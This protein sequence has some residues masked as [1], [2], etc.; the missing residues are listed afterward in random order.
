MKYLHIDTFV[1]EEAA[2]RRLYVLRATGDTPQQWPIEYPA[3]WVVLRF[4]V[5]RSVARR[6]TARLLAQWTRRRG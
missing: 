1:S 6:L 3:G 2:H 5:H 4:P